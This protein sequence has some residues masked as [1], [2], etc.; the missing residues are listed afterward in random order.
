M[1]GDVYLKKVIDFKYRGENLKFG[2]SQDIFSSFQVD[3]GTR[4]LLRTLD[5][6]GTYSFQKIL[7]LGCGYGPLGLAL[8][9]DNNAAVVHMVDRD[10][11]A[12]EFARQNTELNGVSKGTQ[13]YGS[14]G[15]DDIGENDFDLIISNV[16]GKAGEPVI[17]HFLRD[18]RYFVRLGGLVAVVV[19]NAIAPMVEG[20]LSESADIDIVLHQPRSGHA[21]FHYRFIGES[22]ETGSSYGKAIKRGVYDREETVFHHNDVNWQMRTGHGLPEFDSLHYRTRL[23]LDGVSDTKFCESGHVVVM[24]PGQGHVPVFLWHILRPDKITLIDRDLLSL[25]Y[26]QQNLAL[27][28]CPEERVALLH[29]VGFSMDVGDKVGLVAGVLR[30]EEGPQ[31]VFETVKYASRYLIPGGLMLLAASSTAVARLIEMIKSETSIKLMERT[32]R[33]GYC[34]LVMKLV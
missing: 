27:N 7:D 2:V 28:G 31:A 33:R 25:R 32:K 3:I 9:S 23:L 15:Y 10:A 1:H 34:L 6:A 19:V 4:F 20:I 29:R 5:K 24:N 16:P 12:V 17:T 11:L 30:E 21:V 22:G 26:S 18:A 13:V 8:K 14:L